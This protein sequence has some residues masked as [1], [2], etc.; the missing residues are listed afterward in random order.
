[1]SETTPGPW[2]VSHP[3]NEP[4]ESK[5]FIVSTTEPDSW[6]AFCRYDGRE[7]ANA[8][9]IARAPSMAAEIES[10]TA[11][12]ERNRQG[13]EFHASLADKRYWEIES[14]TAERDRL[15]EENEKLEELR[16]AWQF[17]ANRLK[18]LYNLEMLKGAN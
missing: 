16:K 12:N 3:T 10:L 1:M 13:F 7:E 2:F 17:E 15:R 6:V 4:D 9:L 11:E 8:L 5:G 18:T 14:L